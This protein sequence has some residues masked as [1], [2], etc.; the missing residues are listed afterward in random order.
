MRLKTK[1][2]FYVSLFEKTSG[3][4]TPPVRHKGISQF[5][6]SEEEAEFQECCKGKLQDH[7]SQVRPEGGRKVENSKREVF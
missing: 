6:G 4:Y 1:V 7:S 2:T 3:K 5:S